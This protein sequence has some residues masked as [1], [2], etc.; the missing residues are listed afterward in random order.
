MGLSDQE[1]F[2][3][4]C[5]SDSM[6]HR[7][8]YRAGR[9]QIHSVLEIRL[10]KETWKKIRQISCDRKKSYSWV[11]RY[12]LFRAIKRK[13]PAEM[14]SRG[15]HEKARNRRFEAALK[16]R[17]RLCLYGED[18]IYIR[19]AAARL[20]CTMTHLVRMAL[21]F[22][23]ERIISGKN[24]PRECFWT[25]LGTKLFIGV[26]FHTPSPSNLSFLMKPYPKTT[27]Y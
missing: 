24:Y 15:L 26:E 27:Y 23:L 2:I 7:S 20:R 17:H 16:H 10:C 12:A 18:E 13:N 4:F 22:Y 8:Q 14:F 5:D 3:F 6:I 19:L 11:V 21:E 9:L 1:N 25:R